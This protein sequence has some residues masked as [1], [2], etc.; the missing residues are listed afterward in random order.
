MDDLAIANNARGGGVSHGNPAAPLEI[1][2]GGHR[3]DQ[4]VLQLF[5]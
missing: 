4:T 1:A 2:P 3:A 5:L